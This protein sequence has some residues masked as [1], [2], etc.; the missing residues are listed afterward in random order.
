[1][2]YTNAIET[3]QRMISNEKA[4]R[5]FMEKKLKSKF[6]FGLMGPNES[7]IKSIQDAINRSDDELEILE[8]R[9]GQYVEAQKQHERSLIDSSTN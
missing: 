4:H 5:A 7:T 8:I 1:M 9:L 3:I 2:D 6:F